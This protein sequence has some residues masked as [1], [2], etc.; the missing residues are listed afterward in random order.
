MLPK[1]NR[2]F[3]MLAFTGAFSNREVAR[4]ILFETLPKGAGLNEEVNKAIRAGVL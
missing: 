4:D 2:P 3:L 1:E